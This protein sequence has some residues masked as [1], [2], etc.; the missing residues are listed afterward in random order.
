MFRK[1]VFSKKNGVH[2]PSWPRMSHKS[3][4]NICINTETLLS[5]ELGCMTSFATVSKVLMQLMPF[6]NFKLKASDQ[7]LFAYEKKMP[8]QWMPMLTFYSISE[9]QCCAFKE[10]FALKIQEK[11]HDLWLE[12]LMPERLVLGSRCTNRETSEFDC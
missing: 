6:G 11:T 9:E 7:L 2:T 12:M 3:Y 8:M 10:N 1:I 4:R 5:H